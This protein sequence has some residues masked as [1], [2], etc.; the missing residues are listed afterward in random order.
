RIPSRRTH[1]HLLIRFV[2]I[3]IYLCFALLRHHRRR[4]RRRRRKRR[5]KRARN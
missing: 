1:H 3:S 2:S 4:R 5:E